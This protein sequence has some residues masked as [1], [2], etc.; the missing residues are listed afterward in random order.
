MII[1]EN[2]TAILTDKKI[3]VP[4]GTG[5]TYPNVTNLII[6]EPV[7]EIDIPNSLFPNIQNV[8]SHSKYFV[9]N[10]NVLIKNEYMKCILLNTFFK[11][12]NVFLDTRFFTIT[13]IADYALEG[14][15][16]I[17]AL[18]K[19]K[20]LSS[21]KKNVFAGSPFEK[22]DFEN[23]IKCVNGILIDI[24][25]GCK[26]IV[27]KENISLFCEDIDYSQVSTL[28]I[29]DVN[30]LPKN[31]HSVSGLKTIIFDDKFICNSV[32]KLITI[33]GQIKSPVD[34]IF[35]N[36]NKYCTIDNIVYTKDKSVLIYCPKWITGSINI[37]YGVKRIR[38]QV[39]MYSNISSVSFPDTLESIGELA[40]FGSRKLAKIDFGAGLRYIGYNGERLVFSGCKELSNLDIPSNVEYIGLDAFKYCKNLKKVTFH[41]GLKCI[42][43]NAFYGTSLNDI[44]LPRSI[45]MIG[46][47]AFYLADYKKMITFS[48]YSIPQ[49]LIN[50]ITDTAYHDATGNDCIKIESESLPCSLFITP[51]IRP[52]LRGL[53]NKQLNDCKNDEAK[54]SIFAE[55]HI[56]STDSIRDDIILVRSYIE[57][58]SDTLKERLIKYTDR[59]MKNIIEADERLFVDFISLDFIYLNDFDDIIARLKE[60]NYTSGIAYLVK[61]GKFKKSF[62]L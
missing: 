60:K 55:L 1:I 49:N 44:K 32:D 43:D 62:D 31:M 22:Q 41:E 30:R 2:D 23:G 16:S 6:E 61:K 3:F 5:E 56:Q 20:N 38:K 35:E 8:K 13:A 50:A 52:D 19:L 12:Y 21:C 14:C 47:K 53:Y 9:N 39:F 11:P 46:D 45:K 36:N 18:D 7:E 15:N 26:E 10:A 37:P 4:R 42:Q 34:I 29:Q 54:L 27:I 48:L 51:V 40:F 24:E 25:P 33:M 58:K 59:I 28:R 57:T 17:N